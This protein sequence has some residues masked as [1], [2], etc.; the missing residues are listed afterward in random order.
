MR[1][2][3]DENIRDTTVEWL[4]T[5]GHDAVSVKEVGIGGADDKTVLNY[6]VTEGRVLLTFN[7]HFADVRKLATVDHGGIIRLRFK[8]QT[9]ET[10]HPVLQRVLEKLHD[11]DTTNLLITVQKEKMRRRRSRD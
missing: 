3:C 7:T 4:R 5:R 8:I 1:L 10:V 11:E 2:F 9:E 6:A